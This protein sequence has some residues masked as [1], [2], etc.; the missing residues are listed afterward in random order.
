MGV[1][2]RGGG[3][4]VQFLNEI[5][6][7]PVDHHKGRLFNFKIVFTGVFTKQ[8]A[9]TVKKRPQKSPWTQFNVYK[10]KRQS[11]MGLRKTPGDK[12]TQLPL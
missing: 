4:R 10:A 12:Y 3:K 8:M 9:K 1:G 11:K 5:L 2:E 6:G 7:A